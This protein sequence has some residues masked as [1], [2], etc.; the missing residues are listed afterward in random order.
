MGVGVFDV[1]AE[2][3]GC[4]GVGGAFVPGNAIRETNLFS[5]SRQISH[6]VN[7]TCGRAGKGGGGGNNSIGM[8]AMMVHSF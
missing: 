5:Q 2:G 4:G 1:L 7:C 8:M 6:V 3:V